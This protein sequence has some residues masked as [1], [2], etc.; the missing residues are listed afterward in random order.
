MSATNA[1]PAHDTHAPHARPPTPGPLPD[2]FG[3]ALDERVRRWDG[4]RSLLGGHPT[5][6]LRLTAAGAAAVDRWAAGATPAGNAEHALARRLVAGGHAHPLPPAG[7]LDPAAVTVVVPVRDRATQLDRCLAALDADGARVLVVD[8]GSADARAVARMAAAHGVALVRHP[9]S[10][11]ASA[12]RNSGVASSDTPLIAFVDSDCVPAPGWLARLAAHLADPQ[13]AA[14]APRIVAAP[15]TRTTALGRYE[16]DRSPLD[17]GPRP[18]PVAPLSPIPYVPSAALLVRRAA[19]GGGFDETLAI[20]EDV[21]LVWRMRAAGWSVRYDPSV[22]VAHAHRD[23]LRPWLRRRFVYGTSAAALATR[24]R[25]AIPVAVLTPWSMASW[26]LLAARRPR[27]AA[28]AAVLGA[29]ALHARLG[30]AAP[31][32]VSARL[33]GEALGWSGRALALALTRSW[34]PLSL[35]LA[36]RSRRMRTALL[37]ALLARAAELARAPRRLPLTGALA[38]SAADDAAYA[39]GLWWGCLRERSAAPLLP[40]MLLGGAAS[41]SRRG[42]AGRSTATRR[43]R[44]ATWRGVAPASAAGRSRGRGSPRAPRDRPATSDPIP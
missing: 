33:Q 1:H 5:R 15:S 18:G 38:L 24:H 20:G 42:T 14:V 6:L 39:T 21:D 10:R 9:R 44:R 30:T 23:A 26:A 27:A 8:D 25:G 13:V 40:R 28:A 16:A 17:M 31:P 11:G 35:P 32:V 36:A 12:A 34:L 3:I 37:A 4:G 29:A 2:G 19:L 41:G 7:P 43:L 22:A